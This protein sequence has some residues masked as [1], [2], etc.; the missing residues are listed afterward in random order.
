M[1]LGP[2]VSHSPPKEIAAS[3]VRSD[4]ILIPG[5]FGS[6]SSSARDD[7]TTVFTVV[8]MAHPAGFEPAT[9]GLEVPSVGPMGVP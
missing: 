4:P 9:D 6:F 2:L 1:I 3:A 5:R 8:H 7:G